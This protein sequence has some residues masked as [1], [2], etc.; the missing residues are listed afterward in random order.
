M[1]LLSRIAFSEEPVVWVAAIN[2]LIVLGVSFGLPITDAQKLA[3]DGVITG[4]S[5]V[6]L[7]GQVAPQSHVDALVAAK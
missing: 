2:A 5:A 7:R 4:V 6:F 3:I 1:N